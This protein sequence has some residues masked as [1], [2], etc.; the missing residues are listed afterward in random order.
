MRRLEEM[1]IAFAIY[2]I[3]EHVRWLL[4]PKDGEGGL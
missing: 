4:E 2:L 3:R 1:D